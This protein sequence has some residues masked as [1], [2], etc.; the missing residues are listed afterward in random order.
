MAD[1]NKYVV[2]CTVYIFKYM[3]QFHCVMVRSIWQGGYRLSE[4]PHRY[5]LILYNFTVLW[6]DRYDKGVIGYLK[7]HI[8]IAWYYTWFYYTHLRTC[9]NDQV[10]QYQFPWLIVMHWG[11]KVIPRTWTS[12]LYCIWFHYSLWWTLLE[13]TKSFETLFTRRVTIELWGYRVCRSIRK[14]KTCTFEHK[15]LY[16]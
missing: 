9:S 7:I 4:D 14:K 6:W 2:L 3:V 15:S 13:M 1:W 10:Q 5:Y 16:I 8:D 12:R 11:L